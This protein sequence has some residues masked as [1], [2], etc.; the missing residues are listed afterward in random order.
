MLPRRILAGHEEMS[1]D[2]S[3]SDDLLGRIDAVLG[4]LLRQARS[5]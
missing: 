1:P 3:E 5:F 2:W 4:G